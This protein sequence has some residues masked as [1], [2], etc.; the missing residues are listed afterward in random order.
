MRF[1]NRKHI[2]GG[3]AVLGITFAA[4]GFTLS[5]SQATKAQSASDK[6]NQTVRVG[7]YEPQKAFNNYYGYDEMN[8]EMQQLQGEMQQ[9]QQEGDR[10][11]LQQLQQ[12]MQQ[13]QDETI[14]QFYDDV[15]NAVPE[16]AKDSGVSIV[17][18]EILYT[19]DQVEEPKN[20]TDPI[21]EKINEGANDE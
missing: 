4:I 12:R 17:A 5:T 11:R 3:V 15:E 18:V 19:E 8:Q 21:I 16:V 2:L 20:L 1:G 6:Q 9:A 13:L 14:Q 7:T 10:Q